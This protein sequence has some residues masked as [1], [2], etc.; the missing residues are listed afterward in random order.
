MGLMEI[1]AC[2]HLGMAAAAFPYV[3]VI[4]AE[5][6][7]LLG[8]APTALIMAALVVVPLVHPLLL[9]QLLPRHRR[10]LSFR[11]RLAL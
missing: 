1:L 6:P 9:R 11:H 3:L 8:V 5:A 7:T 2:A 10:S 4:A